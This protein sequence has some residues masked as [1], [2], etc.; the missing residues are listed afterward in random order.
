MHPS[1]SECAAWHDGAALRGVVW[2]MA[3]NGV[4]LLAA[5]KHD[6]RR[7]MLEACAEAPISATTI[8]S[9]SYDMSL[10]CLAQ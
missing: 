8:S 2:R 3:G 9:S 10:T 6:E 4:T 5:A 1:L 7:G